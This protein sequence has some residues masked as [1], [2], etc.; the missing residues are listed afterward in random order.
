M[1]L[2]PMTASAKLHMQVV[3]LTTLSRK[4]KAAPHTSGAAGRI[5]W[6]VRCRSSQILPQTCTNGR[7][8][9]SH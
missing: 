5:L 1:Y 3:A 4:A 9:V 8:T 2:P 7:H 6:A